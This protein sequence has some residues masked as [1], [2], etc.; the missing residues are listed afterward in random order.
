[1]DG[2]FTFTAAAVQTQEETEP[3]GDEEKAQDGEQ[4]SG[5]DEQNEDDRAGQ[6]G[7]GEQKSGKNEQR[8][9]S[10][11][12][13]GTQKAG[14]RFQSGGS[15]SGSSAGGTSSGAASV[16]YAGSWNN[17]LESLTVDGHEFTQTFN[18]T[19]GTY[20][21]TADKTETS[22]DVTAEPDDDDATVVVTGDSELESGR[23]KVMVSVTAENGDVRVYRIYVDKE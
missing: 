9:K 20:F 14:K 13:P 11:K 17:Y 10:G 7:K 3:S 19:R 23:N 5:T 4:E 12:M 18:K 15:F 2:C 8:K 22:L 6:S 1:M 21:M 16:T